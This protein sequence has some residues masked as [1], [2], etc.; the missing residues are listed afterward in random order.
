MA[1]VARFKIFGASKFHHKNEVT[2]EIDRD[3][4][5]IQVRPK[6]FKKAYEARLQDVADYVIWMS[7]KA[8]LIEKKKN[9]KKA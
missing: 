1:R 4:G 9:K 8:A 6:H 3:T 7:I 5:F 2:V